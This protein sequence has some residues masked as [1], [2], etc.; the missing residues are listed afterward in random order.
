MGIN[1]RSRLNMVVGLVVFA[2]L[3]SGCGVLLPRVGGGG[4]TAPCHEGTWELSGQQ[5]S[6]AITSVFGDLTVTPNGSGMTLELRSDNTF[7]FSGEQSLDVWGS[8]PYG[9]VDGTVSADAN[10]NGTYSADAT[11]IT[12]VLQSVSGSGQF[13]GTVNNNPFS[14]SFSLDQIGLDDVYGLSGTATTS[15]SASQLT[16]DFADIGWDF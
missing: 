3:S 10:A 14:A 16:L 2:L 7:T 9:T 5:I 6:D 8:T 11:S 4:G 15:C 1:T 13:V 12:F